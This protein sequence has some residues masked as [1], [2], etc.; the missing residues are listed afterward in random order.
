LK[1]CG[2]KTVT[3]REQ[4][5][6]MSIHHARERRQVAIATR[7]G[8][9]LETLK[10]REH[11]PV[12]PGFDVSLHR[13]ELGVA[14]RCFLPRAHNAEVR[15]I[16]AEHSGQ[17]RSKTCA[18]IDRICCR[19]EVDSTQPFDQ[20]VLTAI[21]LLHGKA[22]V[23]N[24]SEKAGEV[25]GKEVLLAS[26]FASLDRLEQRHLI[27][28]LDA[29]PKTEPGGKTRRYFTVTLSGERALAVAKAT[30]PAVAKALEGFA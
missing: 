20:L 6:K 25:Q 27:M 7:I 17:K 3:P 23:A 18:D 30:I 29:D 13:L 21:Y 24:V 1:V 28:G 2:S 8:E 11:A 15:E 14:Q 12:R 10:Q 22:N 9:L 19:T 5:P 16:D 4:C 26:T